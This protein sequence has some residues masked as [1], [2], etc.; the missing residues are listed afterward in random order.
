MFYASYLLYLFT[1]TKKHKM[2]K[3][4]K[5]LQEYID[6]QLC[7]LNI[8]IVKNRIEFI[9]QEISNLDNERFYLMAKLFNLQNRQNICEDKYGNH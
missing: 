3:R 6:D 8:D 7:T 2:T 4:D 1:T 5:Q 9:N